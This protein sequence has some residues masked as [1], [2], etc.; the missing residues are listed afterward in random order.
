MSS[1]DSC[2]QGHMKSRSDT[3]PWLVP[4]ALS[5]LILPCGLCCCFTTAAPLALLLLLWILHPSY[6]PL[7][8]FFPFFL[9]LLLLLL[10]LLFIELLSLLS[11]H[12]PV[13]LT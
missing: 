3:Y 4:L 13:I 5:P 1:Y 2:K 7:F 12:I 9:L 8:P 10:F 6:P 11:H